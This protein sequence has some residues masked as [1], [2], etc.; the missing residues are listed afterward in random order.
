MGTNPVDSLPDADR[1]AAWLAACPFVVVSDVVERTDTTKFAHVLLPAQAWGEKDG[2]VTNSERRIS[3]QRPL[4][5]VAGEAMPDWWA[6][7]GVARRMGFA[8]AF[9]YS[10]PAA[11]FREHAALSGY[12]NR[13]ARDFD[14]SALAR[15]SNSE[16][17]AL[18]PFQW[19]WRHGEAASDAPK[20][21]FADGRFYA[22]STHGHP[23]GRVVALDPAKS[24][25]AQWREIVRATAG[26]LYR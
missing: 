24:A 12:Q 5:V 25:S 19:P 11:I 8:R 10:G 9:D 4:R 21:F 6:L 14:I 17:D 22:T 20:R 1:V 15:I 18:R 23:N 2:T 16:F 7:C 13:G 26:G 3:R